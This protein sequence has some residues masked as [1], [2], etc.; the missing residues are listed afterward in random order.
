MKLITYQTIVAEVK[1]LCI[2]AN[3]FLGDDVKTALKTAWH[4]EISPL[5]KE[6]L[7]A[8]YRNSLI[9]SEEQVP[10]CQDTGTAVVFLEIGQDVRIEGGYIYDAV[11]EG[12]RQGYT[13]GYLRK[14]MVNHP[15][16]RR[17][18]GD[19]T[20][21]IIHAE[22]V[23]GNQLAI[24]VA[25]K[26]GGSENMSALAML[27]PSAGWTGVKQFVIETVRKAGANPCPPLIVGVG[28][29]GNFEKAALLAKKSL[30]R[31]VGSPNRDAELAEL[32]KEL[33]KEINN[34]GIG[35]QGFGGSVTALAVHIE[36]YPCHIASLPVAVNL[37]CHVARHKSVIL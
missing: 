11:N 13:E 27:T 35:P 25:P 6:I 20:P 30:L 37:N 26:G 19:N 31:E 7:S 14:S 15:L 34:L 5:G 21:A 10:I 1:K 28:I 4:N 18:T 32:E 17:N 8:L 12:V 16:C 2:E 36:L 23:P 22:I 9:A 33:I 29:G 24:T 3:Y